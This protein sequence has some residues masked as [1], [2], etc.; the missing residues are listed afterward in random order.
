MTMTKEAIQYLM[1]QGIKPEDRL[2]NFDNDERWLVIDSGGRS[3]E[4][5]PRVFTAKEH[6]VIK[7]LSGF[8]NYVKANLDRTDKPLIVHVK[9]E[10][11]VV[12]NGLLEVD[13]SRETLA[14]AKAIVPRFDFD[15]FLDMEDFNISL[16]SKFVPNNYRDILLKVVGNV[17][18][19]NVKSTGDDG[20]SQAVTI[21]QGVATKA[22]VK[23]PN[24]VTLAPF[25][26]FLEVKQPE[27]QFIFRMKDGPRGAIFEADGGAWRN[28][29]I[30][31]IREYLKE[32]LSEEIEAGRITIIA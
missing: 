5:L 4:L 30:V 21:N 3:E 23:V 16:Q 29:A 12:L 25:R 9:N 20:V 28:Q 19:D 10:S 17:S 26:T 13:G 6:L 18:E 15:Y 31:N 7:T 8:V 22:S 14:V 2:I 11:S 24:P 1:E 32:Q 27:S